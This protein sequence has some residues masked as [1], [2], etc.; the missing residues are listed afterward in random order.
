MLTVA[1]CRVATE[2]QAA[3]GFS[4]EGQ[5][6]KLRTYAKLHDLGPL[7]FIDDPGLSGKD[8]N[9]PGLQQ[10]LGLADQGGIG[11]I[12]VWRL[13]R[14]SR[15]LGDLILLAEQFLTLGVG[16]HS[17][18]ENLDLSTASGRMYFNIIGTFAQFYREQLSEN[19]KMGM[20]QAA[21]D[22]RWTNRP[23]TG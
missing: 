15:N 13:D 16:L 14:L 5:A 17:V 8:L 12:V 21:R 4:I 6:E 18:T 10:I 22:G 20:S 11:N 23:K 9:R 1:Y 2:E 19:V 7:T 3:E